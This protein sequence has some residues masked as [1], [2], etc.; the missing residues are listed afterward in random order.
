MIIS[1]ESR[2]FE[3]FLI[4]RAKLRPENGNKGLREIKKTIMPQ[5]L[6]NKHFSL[7]FRFYMTI[8]VFI[9]YVVFLKQA[10]KNSYLVFSNFEFIDYLCEYK[11]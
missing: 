3:V 4:L 7:L 11:H 8:V 6:D 10:S 2:L 5:N 1:Q 9:T